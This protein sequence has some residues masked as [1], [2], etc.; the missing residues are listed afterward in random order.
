MQAVILAAGKGTRLRPLTDRYPKPLIPLVGNKR[1]LD[2]IFES[3]PSK[4]SEVILVVSSE[5]RKEFED[6]LAQKSFPFSV[7]IKNQSYEHRG[8]LGAL[9]SIKNFLKEEPFLVLHG[10]DL[11]SKEDIEKFVGG[12]T[13]AMSF[14]KR[15]Y[16]PNYYAFDFQNGYV[17]SFRPQTDDEKENGAYIASGMYI[18][19]HRIFSFPY[20]FVSG[21]ELGLPQTILAQRRE[22]PIQAFIEERWVPINTYDDLKRAKRGL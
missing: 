6:F 15:K 2:F 11:H 1:I 4:V 19:D 7:R 13:Y 18:L 22:Y 20:H 17:D 8:T 3:L 16:N 21:G 5:K 9:L 10:D 14:A 12:Y